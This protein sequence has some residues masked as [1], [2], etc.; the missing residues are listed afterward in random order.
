M[1]VDQF[2]SS[3]VVIILENIVYSSYIM[4]MFSCGVKDR[5]HLYAKEVC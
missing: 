5:K 1:F 4:L 3:S 2:E